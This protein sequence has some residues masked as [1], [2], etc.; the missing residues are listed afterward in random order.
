M[1]LVSLMTL[2][3]WHYVCTFIALQIYDKYTI[4]ASLYTIILL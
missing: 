2:L 3:Y 4:Y 1:H